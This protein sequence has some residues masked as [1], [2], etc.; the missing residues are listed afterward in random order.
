MANGVSTST[1]SMIEQ[2]EEFASGLLELGLQPGDKVATISNNRP[3]W[4][5]VDL[6]ILLAGMINVPIYPTITEDDYEYI[7]N[8]AETKTLLYF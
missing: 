8:N 4:H 2:A 5:I 1:Q 3:E 7:M 6:G